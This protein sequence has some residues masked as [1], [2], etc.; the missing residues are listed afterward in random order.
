MTQP[1]TQTEP[2]KMQTP[3]TNSNNRQLKRIKKLRNSAN[4][5]LH[6]MPQHI[7]PSF[8]TPPDPGP[9]P[10]NT[11]TLPLATKVLHHT[12]PPKLDDI[13][14]LC[15]KAIASIISKA[16][17]KPMDT[18]QNKEDELYKKSPKRYHNKLKTAA[19][20]QPRAKDQPSLT[21]V[22]DPTTHEITSN[23]QIV[24]DTIQTH[25]EHEH[26]RTTPDTI[27]TPPCQNPNNPDP[28]DT[29]LKNPNQT[30]YFLDHYLTRGNYTMACYKT[31]T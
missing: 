1:Y 29:K 16:N 26:A 11:P 12:D 27:P 17:R 18:I 4:R 22:R 8:P 25:Y 3:L 28:Y 5:K 10:D 7:R 14:S 30:Q 21:T 15:H 31:S 19:G 23:P 9:H 13:P 2:S 24:I 20:L 6:T